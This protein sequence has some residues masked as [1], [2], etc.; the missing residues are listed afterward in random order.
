MPRLWRYMLRYRLR[1]LG[2]ITCLLAATS[3]AMAIPWLQK[4]SFDAI[5]QDAG[6]RV[7]LGYVGLIALT[8]VFQAVARTLSRSVIFNAG[9]D[10]EYDLRNDLFGHLERLPLA[11]YQQRQ[12]GDLMSRLVNDVTAV[13]MLLGPGVLNFINTPVYYLYALPIMFSIHARLTFLALT[14]YPVALLVVKRTSR[15]LMER[16][17]RVQEGLGEL[18]NR[19]QENLSGM[20]VVK[21]YACEGR[22]VETFAEANA[23]FQETSLRL[24]RVRGFIG[25]VMSIVGGTG[26][27]VVLWYGGSQVMAGRLSIG[28]LVAFIGYLAILAWPTMALGWMLSV[29]QRGRAA[30]KRLNE[31]LAIEPAIT[32]PAG[33]APVEPC[34]GEVAFRGVT[35]A[36]PSAPGTRVLDDVDLTVPAGRTVA[37]VGRTGAGKTALVDLL[38]RL[39][40]V[41]EGS[42]LLDGQDVR[43]LPLGWLRRQIGLVRQDP[44]LFSR[45]IRENV[46]F[47]ADDGDGDGTRVED[48]VRMAAL[49]RDL[50]QFPR[51]LETVVGER[52]VTLSGGQKQRVALARVLVAAPRVLVLDDSLSSVDAETERMILDQLRGFF[53]ERTTILVAHRISTIK[54]ADLIFVLDEGRVAEVGDHDGLVARGGVYAALFRQQALEVELE[55][56]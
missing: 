52:G 56:I 44:F 43:T 37:I 12:T 38:P 55:A 20:H 14:I 6:G 28:D 31:I 23:R 3:L 26:S 4:K 21:A 24:A 16:S 47:A 36:Y 19:V 27:L 30:L 32:S 29:L 7:L 22:E 33:A 5:E 34:R 49:E 8:A 48:A 40:D 51:G 42:V 54:E 18:S 35:F 9:R 2:G 13:R 45:T 50:A 17:L 11:F 25:P 39:F 15:L 46:A 53:R 1:Y 41:Q 10:I